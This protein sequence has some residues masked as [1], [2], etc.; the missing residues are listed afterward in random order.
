[1]GK[2]LL[3]GGWYPSYHLKIFRK[4]HGDCENRWMDEH[5]RIFDGTTITIKEGNQVDANLNDLTWWTENTTDM[6][7]VNGRYA[8]DGVWAGCESARSCTK[9]LRYRRTTKTLA[10]NQIH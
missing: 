5:I 10:K 9:V 2:P 1:M 4:G 3:H 7:P 6:L 8:N